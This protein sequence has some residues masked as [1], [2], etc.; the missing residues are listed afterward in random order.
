MRRLRN[1]ENKTPTAQLIRY[2]PVCHAVDIL[3][4]WRIESDAVRPEGG[5]FVLLKIWK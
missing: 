4:L 3:G 5:H 2:L 1:I